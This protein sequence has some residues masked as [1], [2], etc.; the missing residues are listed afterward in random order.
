MNEVVMWEALQAKFGQ[1][2]KLAQQ[3]LGTGDKQL[4]EHTARDDF[5]GDGGGPGK[6]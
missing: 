1:N 4:I 2:P 3:L 6:G 5:W